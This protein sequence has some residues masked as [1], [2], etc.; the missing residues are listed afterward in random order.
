M[1]DRYFLFTDCVNRISAF[2]SGVNTARSFTSPV[3]SQRL[4]KKR[5]KKGVPLGT[6]QT[7]SVLFLPF[8]TIVAAAMLNF[9]VRHG[10]G[11][12]HRAIAARLSAE[13]SKPHMNLS[14]T[15]SVKS[16]TY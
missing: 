6:G 12:V 2:T 8:P 1:C 3:K 14:H 9:R 13:P 10:Y 15:S 5:Q 7:G 16:S 4:R 11:C